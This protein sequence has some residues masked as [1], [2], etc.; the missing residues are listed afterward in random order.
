MH[1]ESPRDGR[2]LLT[3]S[4][5]TMCALSRSSDRRAH[6]SPGSIFAIARSSAESHDAG[7]SFAQQQG[8]RACRDQLGVTESSPGCVARLG[9]AF[10]A[11]FGV[12]WARSSSDSVPGSVPG[13]HHHRRPN[14]HGPSR[15]PGA[16]TR[17]RGSSPTFSDNHPISPQEKEGPLSGAPR[18]RSACRICG[19]CGH[20]RRVL[21]RALWPARIGGRS[22]RPQRRSDLHR[23]ARR[24]RSEAHR[25]RARSCRNLPWKASRV[26]RAPPT[27]GPPSPADR[28]P[29]SRRPRFPRPLAC[30]H[31]A[32]SRGRP[33]ARSPAGGVA[34]A[35]RWRRRCLSDEGESTRCRRARSPRRSVRPR[36]PAAPDRRKVRGLQQDHVTGVAPAL[37]KP[38]RGR[39]LA[40]G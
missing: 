9:R 19:D 38:A 7:S 6:S 11:S 30:A 13:W 28:A 5:L 4:C 39:A 36:R 16:A 40:Q 34:P 37:E 1:R 8:E 31:D 27:T 3:T 25:R 12:R 2:Q 32:S 15:W 22:L 35:R 23:G 14:R 29:R 10:A 17:R 18:G 24:A 26:R 21:A 33:S 20:R